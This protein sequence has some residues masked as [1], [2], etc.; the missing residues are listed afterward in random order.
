MTKQIRIFRYIKYI[1]NIKQKHLTDVFRLFAPTSDS[2]QISL[3]RMFLHLTTDINL[4]SLTADSTNKDSHTYFVFK[5]IL[6]TRPLLYKHTRTQKR[7]P[8]LELP[9]Q[10]SRLR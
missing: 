3:F 10:A 8:T 2:A 4:E 9:K 7:F 5:K 6:S 1:L